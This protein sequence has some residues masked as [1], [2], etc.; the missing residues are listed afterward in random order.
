M[1]EFTFE[2]QTLGS[3][4]VYRL[5][6]G[7]EVD[8]TA[9]GMLNYNDIPGMLPVSCMYVDET[10]TV[11]FQISSLTAL[12]GYW[13]GT[14]SRQKLLAFLSSFC[15]AVLECQEYMLDPGK[16]LLDWEHVF[17]EP[18]SGE[19]RL[20]Y[21][22]VLGGEDEERAKPE[23]FLRS[24]IQRTTF[25]PT[26]DGSHVAVI[27]N[28]LNGGSFSVE[29]F[30]AQLKTLMGAPAKKGAPPRYIEEAEPLPVQKAPV[31]QRPPQPPVNPGV[32]GQ[33][34]PAAAPPRQPVPPAAPPRPA[35]V[36]PQGAGMPPRPPVPG[37]QIPVPPAQPLPPAQ[38]AGK[39]GGFSL[40][41]G[42]KGQKAEKHQKKQPPAPQG[43]GF[44]VPGAPNMGGGAPA[45]PVPP[46]A[47]GVPVPP[48]APGQDKAK[49]G[50]LGF[51]KKKDLI[52][53]APP[54]PVPPQQFQRPVP[55]QQ[56]AQQPYQRP[57]PPHQAAPVGG[58]QP[59]RPAARPVTPPPAPG[60]G[61][62]T[63][64]LGGGASAGH[65]MPLGQQPGAEGQQPQGPVRLCLV[66]KLNG[67]RAVIDKPIFHVGREGR[68]VDFCITG[69]HDW[70][71][72]DHAYFLK[73]EDGYYLVDNNSMN[74]TWLN[75][76]QLVSNQPY[77]VKAGDVIR[78]ADEE[79]EL[80]PG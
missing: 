26:E 32:A 46:A 77:A 62:H 9:L 66:R 69:G 61:G 75:G 25:D 64:P 1:R 31:G 36:P 59:P 48:P 20:A 63:V 49:K 57:V 78:M 35:A 16:L 2:N 54:Q 45:A 11:R 47:P 53:P 80:L 15:R 13:G 30:D 3:F 18:M 40:L 51:G 42:G 65:T 72:K 28:A 76:Q 6:P 4:L 19:V 12:M 5:A 74:H 37:Q 58:M 73:K 43:F 27:F 71:G 41:G 14:I 17:V 67:Q 44:A 10:Q 52:P 79:F 29:Q 23:E 50:L 68:I 8:R 22:P 24:L 38:Q 33:G 60:V 39:K 7:E 21:L 70:V 56:P 55:P 34:F